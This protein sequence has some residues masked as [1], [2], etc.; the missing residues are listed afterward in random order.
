[1]TE[2]AYTVTHTTQNSAAERLSAALEGRS[3][4]V[5]LAENHLI[6][7]VDE[8]GKFT[9]RLHFVREDDTDS[10]QF[11]NQERWSLDSGTSCTNAN[12]LAELIRPVLHWLAHPEMEGSAWAAVNGR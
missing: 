8:D 4:T 6:L 5:D 12:A 2:P 10:F 7:V 3:V 9:I 11:Q 1:M